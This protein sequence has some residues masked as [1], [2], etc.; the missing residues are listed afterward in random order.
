[1]LSGW[2]DRAM[3]MQETWGHIICCPPPF[4]PVWVTER[5]Q[6]VFCCAAGH[7]R[8]RGQ[9]L[10]Q[11]RGAAGV[12]G[13]HLLP[14]PQAEGQPGQHHPGLHPRHAPAA[15]HLPVRRGWSAAAADRAGF[16]SRGPQEAR[17]ICTASGPGCCEVAARR[18]VRSA[19]VWGACRG[20][21]DLIMVY[22]RVTSL[23]GHTSRV[24]ELLEQVTFKCSWC[25]RMSRLSAMSD[26]A[27]RAS[28]WV[29]G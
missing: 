22:K 24:S 2:Y 29:P 8:L 27:A 23:A 20:I 15:E 11:L 21:G 17:C 7:R 26:A 28:A 18:P 4:L 10:C 3:D 9:I 13:A 16:V 25:N 1:M 14:G 5:V 19:I 6:A 12:C